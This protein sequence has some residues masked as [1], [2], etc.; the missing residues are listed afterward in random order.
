MYRIGRALSFVT[1]LLTV[2]AGL[3]ITLMMLH[4]T[5]DV[6]ARTVFNSPLPG[7]ITYVSNWYMV[8]A[9]FIPLAFTEQKSAHISV[10]V[11]VERLP[12][13]VQKHLAGWLL[14]VSIITFAILTL[15][16]FEEAIVKY[17]V[18]ASIVQG[19][20]K[21]WVWPTYFFLPVGCGLMTLVVTYKFLIYLTGQ[22]SGL[23]DEQ[24]DTGFEAIDD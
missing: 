4:V 2:V 3:A 14:P 1:N 19:A 7:T 8:L 9:G 18:G 21:I 16:T 5:A 12:G 6:V 15:R 10:E 17:E 24:S 13:F 20:S 22:P 23:H 11:V